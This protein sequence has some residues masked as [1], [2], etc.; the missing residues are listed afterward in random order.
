MNQETRNKLFKRLCIPIRILIILFM[1]L[2]AD[3]DIYRYSF[4][5]IAIV[6]SVRFSAKYSLKDMV[7]G[8]GG[9]AWWHENRLKHAFLWGLVGV[10][11]IW[12]IRWAG[13]ILILD[14]LIGIISYK[15]K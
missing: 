4:A 1:I 5:V 12:D 13:Y 8:F 15:L 9:H 3:I 14:V 11:L 10:L 7:G 2:L 6:I